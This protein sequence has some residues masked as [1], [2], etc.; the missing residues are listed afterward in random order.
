MVLE[1][2]HMVFHTIYNVLEQ[3]THLSVF[4]KLYR[5]LRIQLM[6]ASHKESALPTAV[7]SFQP[8]KCALNAFSSLP[9][10][11]LILTVF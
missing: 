4:R 9:L 10:V 5:V 2:E 6:L 8:L 3:E 11:Y 7:V 1:I